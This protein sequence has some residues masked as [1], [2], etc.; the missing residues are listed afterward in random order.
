MTRSKAIPP[1]HKPAFDVEGI[2][3]FA[4]RGASPVD[5]DT[6]RVSLTLML[7]PE[8]IRRLQHE[9]SRKGKSIEQ[10]I[11]KLVGK[12]LGKH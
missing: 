1:M 10:I 12:H 8:A 7:K 4:S 5:G 2:L 6:D 9:A 3:M 11:E